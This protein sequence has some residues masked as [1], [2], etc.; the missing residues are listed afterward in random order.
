MYDNGRNDVVLKTVT[1]LSELDVVNNKSC[2]QIITTSRATDSAAVD[3]CAHLQSIFTYLYN[4]IYI[5]TVN[6]KK[7]GNQTF[8]CNFAKC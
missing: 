2:I 6:Q 4:Y 3:N 1:E 8:V 7:S 5:Y